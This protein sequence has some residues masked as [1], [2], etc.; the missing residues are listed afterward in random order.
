MILKT[1]EEIEKM[2]T[3]GKILAQVSEKVRKAATEGISLK[4]LDELANRLIK[5]AG[6]QP[7][8]L[9]YKPHGARKPYAYTICASINDEIVH[10]IPTAYKLK[11]GDLLKLDF[12]V[13]CGGY[14]ADAAWTVGVGKI[15]PEAKKLIAVT[16]QALYAGIKAANAGN[17]LGDIGYSISSFVKK[18]SFQ[19]I[20]GLA[21]HGIGKKLHEDPEVYN[22][23]RAGEGFKLE[24]G[25]VLAIE[26]M[27]SAGS[28]EVIQRADD[29]FVTADGSLSAHF[30]HTVAITKNGTEI[31][32]A[33]Y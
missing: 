8:F 28:P 18:N 4:Y 32:T 21:G 12:G 25:M 30:E 24:S 13:I 23:G 31:I 19:I 15:S 10:G 1:P 33:V 6:A 27:V 16:E 11:S 5:T 2:R 3:A 22:E 9:G 17:T 7:A 14:Y 29:S 26:P 20:K